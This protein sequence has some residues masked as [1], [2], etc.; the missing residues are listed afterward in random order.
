METN[1]VDE[2]KMSSYIR[3]ESPKLFAFL[4]DDIPGSIRDFCRRIKWQI[5]QN[6][7]G[8]TETVGFDVVW[9]RKGWCRLVDRSTQIPCTKWYSGSN[10]YFAIR[11]LY[12]IVRK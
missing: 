6:I 12:S 9:N 8:D 3:T 2:T 11:E 4:R 10:Y 7:T 1:L 5:Q